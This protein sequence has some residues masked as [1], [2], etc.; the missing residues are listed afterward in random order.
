MDKS[1]DVRARLK[2]AWKEAGVATRNLPLTLTGLFVLTCVELF[3]AG[4]IL[5][6]TTETVE[7]FGWVIALAALEIGLSYGCGLL[8][9]LGSGIVAELRAD[10]RPEHRR[11]AGS[12]RTVSTLLAVIPVVFFTNALALQTQRAER[13]QYVASES[14]QLH[15]AMAEDVSL[16]SRARMQ[17]AANL[18]RAAEV[19]T[20]RMDATWFA[21]LIASIFI[22][23]TLGW[24]GTAFYKP[25]PETAWEAKERQHQRKLAMQRERRAERRAREEAELKAMAKSGKVFDLKGHLRGH[26]RPN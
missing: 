26:L 21:A 23:G 19:R 12:A 1:K 11:R 5:Q 8:S 9:F 20:A 7:V 24:A 15:R 4:G 6:S 16:D 13:A 25:K 17:A 2:R 10:P 22:Y 3:T 18:S 14:Y